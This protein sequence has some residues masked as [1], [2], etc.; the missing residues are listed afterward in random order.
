MRGGGTAKLGRS[1][2][3]DRPAPTCSCHRYFGLGRMTMSDDKRF[4]EA[5]RRFDEANGEDPRTELVD[6]RAQARELLFARRVYEWVQKLVA[7][8]SEELLLAARGH[9]LRRWAIPRDRYPR[10]TP[11]YRQWREA[12]A[13]FHAEQAG[14]ILEE[15]GYVELTIARVRA[16]ITREDWRNDPEGRALEDADCLVF[17]E[18]KLDDYLGEWEE[19]KTV[20]ILKKTLRKMTPAGK[21]HAGSL[22]L[23]DRCLELLRRAK[24]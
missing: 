24:E 12:L 17:L 20:N 6:G 3:R 10:T 5:I 19:K 4:A 15:V 21:E 11:G 13:V 7:E 2:L 8:P 14:R 1:I 16:L 22:E 18:T 9:T 23:S